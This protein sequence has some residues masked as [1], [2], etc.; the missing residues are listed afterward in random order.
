M[1]DSL[2]A[3]ACL[4]QGSVLVTSGGSTPT[5]RQITRATDTVFIRSLIRHVCARQRIIK[6]LKWIMV[7]QW[8]GDNQKNY[9]KFMKFTCI[10]CSAPSMSCVCRAQAKAS[11]SWGKWF[12]ATG[13][14]VGKNISKS[15]HL[16]TKPNNNAFLNSRIFDASS[17]TYLKRVLL[18]RKRM[19]LERCSK[20]KLFN[21]IHMG[22]GF[23]FQWFYS[24]VLKYLISILRI[25]TTKT[26]WAMQ[27]G[28]VI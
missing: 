4:A 1:L 10:A 19:G 25:L 23:K 3:M 16:K 18:D 9:F 14:N 2:N 20:G 8:G 26:I 27:K 5:L 12:S 17:A 28:V 22:E 7:C 13:Q 11:G 6:E 21:P 15:I 24:T